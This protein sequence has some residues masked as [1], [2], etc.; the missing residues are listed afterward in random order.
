MVEKLKHKSEKET[1]KEKKQKT[2]V[3]GLMN[4]NLL[5]LE[6]KKLNCLLRHK[7]EVKLPL[8]LSFFFILAFSPFIVTKKIN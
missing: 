4:V 3:P 2:C 1:K 8:P 6:R 7:K 5:L